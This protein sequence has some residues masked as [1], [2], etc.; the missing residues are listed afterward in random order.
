M[1]LNDNTPFEEIDRVSKPVC[2]TM[3]DRYVIANHWTKNKSVLDAATGK[4]YGAMILYSLG[5]KSVTGIDIDKEGIRDANKRFKKENVSFHDCDIF[6]LKKY[7]SDEKFD[8]CT[9]IETFEHLPPER[10]DEY[11]QSILKIQ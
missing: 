3:V 4:G 2:S 11:L 9:S 1:K 5:A 8:V 6:N 7:F 10:I